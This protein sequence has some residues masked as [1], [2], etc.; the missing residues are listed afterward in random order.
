MKNIFSRIALL[1]VAVV[2]IVACDNNDE[3]IVP[4]EKP[5][6]ELSADEVEA[7]ANGGSYSLSYTITNPV[8]EAML[9]VVSDQEW[10][11]DITVAAEEITF[12]VA[13]NDAAEERV[14][15]LRVEYPE[16]EAQSFVVKQQGVE[17]VPA[18]Y[19]VIDVQE[20]HATS[21]ITQVTPADNEMYYVMYLEEVSY[22]QNGGI[23][24]QELLWEDDFDAFERN[25]SNNGMNLK[26]YMLQVNVAFQGVKRVKW[27]DVLPGVKSVLYVYGIQF[28]EDGSSYE[29][30]TKVAWE[31]IEPEYAP[32]QD[33][34]FDLD[35]E[36]DGA[37]VA[38]NVKPENWDGYYVVK[39]V[40]GNDDLYM[41]NGATFDAEDMKSIADEWISVLNSNLRGGHTLDTILSEICCKGDAVVEAQLSSYT[42]YSALVFPVA[43][44][45]GFVQVVAE[46]SYINFSTEEVQQSDMDINIE[47]S[48]CYVRVADLKI[49][50]S[51]PDETYLL[52]IT[53]TE[54]LPADYDD[55]VLLDMA[56]GEF[57]YY[58][59]E[60]K[61]E[62]TTHL[63]T[64]YPNKE[65]IVVAFGYSGG[66]VTTDV[67]SKVFKTE[68]EGECELEI[69]DVII[70]GP[71]RPSDLYNYDPVRFKYYAQNYTPDTSI[72]VVSIEVKTSEPTDDIFAYPFAV[73][74]YEWAGHETIF[75]DL[76][77][78][79]CSAL[80]L[81]DI[82]YDDAPYY[83]CAAAFDYKGNVTPMWM[84]EQMAWSADETKPIKELI[85]KLEAS[86]NVMLM[87]V[88][89]EGKLVP[90][91]K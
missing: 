26:E 58:T 43:E 42:L 46:P 12:V 90:L 73:M 62:V 4:A 54:Y 39:F 32:L 27:N 78:D 31:V 91:H 37:E 23:D 15:T 60:F 68:P 8:E 41:G 61:G 48:N 57:I 24:T 28:N 20:V 30:V 5:V 81:S 47:V 3:P 80:E 76:L 2:A 21:A 85:Q 19:F 74:D 72:G 88:T 82:V 18:D 77:I 59:Y 38:L 6:V 44:Y 87:G 55:E 11:S 9:S 63:N 29:P 50:P 25:A 75:Y 67:C 65:Y 36:V 71:Y 84:S 45:D 35:I 86:P 64:L 1:L 17:P 10:V 53:P 40:D 52:L 7:E 83:V 22:F 89:A 79:T 56:L 69:T 14:A 33:V 34:N 66:V 13:A 51:N 49:T 70:G 16:T